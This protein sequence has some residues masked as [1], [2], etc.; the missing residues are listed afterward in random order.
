VLEA[1][2]LH[3]RAAFRRVVPGRLKPGWQMSH[4]DGSMLGAESG[5]HGHLRPRRAA[6]SFFLIAPRAAAGARLIDMPTSPD[7]PRRVGLS[8]STAD[9][10]I[11]LP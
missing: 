4:A 9:G 10:K 5:T 6:R 3:A 1:A 2:T 11:L 8:L 7:A